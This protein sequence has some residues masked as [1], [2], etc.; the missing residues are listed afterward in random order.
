MKWIEWFF[1]DG[2]MPRTSCGVW[3]TWL[4]WE[5]ILSNATI[6]IV[7]WL[8]FYWFLKDLIPALRLHTDVRKDLIGVVV[9]GLFVC[10]C[11]CTH[12]FSNV[13]GFVWPC[14]PLYTQIDLMT[15]LVSLL[16]L[17]YSRYLSKKIKNTKSL[18]KTEAELQEK[19][20]LIQKSKELESGLRKQ[21]NQ[22]LETIR[23]LNETV[24]HLQRLRSLGQ[25]SHLQSVV[26]HT[27]RD[28]LNSVIL[29]LSEKS[30]SE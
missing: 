20:V 8:I 10:L 21:V 15:A 14:Y 28:N 30:K 17:R 7:Y 19:N 2:F 18:F 1:G 11:G 22:D 12:F 3:P 13:L 6:A 5:N 25:W 16:F 29:P 4:L 23:I 9:F 26:F 24:D 27:I